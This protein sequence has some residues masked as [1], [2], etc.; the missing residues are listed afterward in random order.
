M[1]LGKG[2]SD[3]YV[4]LQGRGILVSVVCLGEEKW[5]IGRKA[6]GQREPSLLRPSLGYY[7]LT[8]AQQWEEW[9][10]MRETV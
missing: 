7:F 5:V 1:A 8:P 4:L 10:V 2:G 3:F 9:I 6:G